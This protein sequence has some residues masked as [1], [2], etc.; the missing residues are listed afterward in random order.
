MHLCVHT[1]PHT[2]KCSL[3]NSTWVHTLLPTFQLFPAM[4][5]A[6]HIS[7]HCNAQGHNQHPTHIIV[8]AHMLIYMYT[9]LYAYTVHTHTC[10]AHAC[11]NHHVHLHTPTSN[12]SSPLKLHISTHAHPCTQAY[13]G[14]R[15]WGFGLTED[16][17]SS[18]VSFVPSPVQARSRRA[19]GPG[20]FPCDFCEYPRMETACLPEQLGPG[21][22]AS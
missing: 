6:T 1:A 22:S 2:F 21:K 10:E 5:T 11:A 8:C 14:H 17:G 3:H 18:G 13:P 12:P 15:S 7:L 4:P 20:Q 9:H 19:R 16:G